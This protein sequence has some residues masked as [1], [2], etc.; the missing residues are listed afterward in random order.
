MYRLVAEAW[1][2]HWAGEIASRD[3]ATI[4]EAEAVMRDWGRFGVENLCD[5]ADRICIYDAG[6]RPVRLWSARH[7][8]SLPVDATGMPA[9]A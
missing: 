8:R 5:E 6:N 3:C 1:S 9:S 4:E 7:R 2:Q